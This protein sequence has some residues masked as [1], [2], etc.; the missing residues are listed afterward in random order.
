M[1]KNP[2]MKNF[3]SNILILTLGSIIMLSVCIALNIE[4]II[5][6][7]IIMLALIIKGGLQLNIRLGSDG[8]VSYCKTCSIS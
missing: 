6:I 2:M 4:V 5:S 7:S 1:G 3:I 8:E